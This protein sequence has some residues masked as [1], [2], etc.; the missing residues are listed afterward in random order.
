MRAW[1]VPVMLP[2]VLRGQVDADGLLRQARAQIVENL[3]RLP[4]YT[5]VQTIRRSRYEMFYGPRGNRC[6]EPAKARS[7]PNRMQIL[8]AWTDRFKLDVT[9]ADGSEIFSWAGARRFQS[10][11]A[12]EIV[13]G[14]LTGSGDFGPFLMDIFGAAGPEYHYVGQERIGGQD[15]AAYQYQVPA[16]ASHYQIKAGARPADMVTLAYEGEFW[17]DPQTAGLRRLSIVVPKPPPHAE[18]CRI[19]TE[20]DYQPVRIGGAPLV[21]PQS[22]QLKLWDADGSR[23][24]NQI[25]YES[26]RAFQSESVFRP[27]VEGAAGDAPAAAPA[28]RAAPVIPAGLTLRIALHSPIDMES[29]F[30]G[31]AI[32][33]QL[34]E[35]IRS[36]GGA[37]VAPVGTIVNGRIVRAERHFVPTSF[38]AL[39]LRFDSMVIGGVEVP[40]SLEAVPRSREAQMLMGDLKGQGIG[41]FVFHGELRVLDDGFDAEWRTR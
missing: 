37:I 34:E 30:A 8:L 29:A 28:A 22:T 9:V 12:Q 4:K 26:C 20:I 40:V 33:G 15:L 27:E 19:E 21:L 16:A 5:C 13:G 36:P 25:G 17:I 24:E 14:G 35:P 6:G 38:F 23:Y 7:G 32:E 3:A 18:T 39:G 11:D 31:D 1:I 2:L 10:G 41:M